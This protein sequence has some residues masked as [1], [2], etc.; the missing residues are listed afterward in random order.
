LVGGEGTG[1]VGADNGGA[2]ESFDGWEG[3]DDGVLFGHSV[4]TESQTGGD[5]GW[6]TFWDGGNSESDGNFEVVDGTFDP[7]ATVHWIVEVTDVDGPDKNAND[8]DH[9]G[10]L[11]TEFV[12]FFGEW[13]LF[14]FGFNHGLSDFTDF[15]VL[16][17]FS[18]DTDS[19]SRS[20]VGTR[21]EQID[22]ILIDGSVVWNSF[23]AFWYRNRFSGQKSLIDSESGG[24]DF[25]DSEI[26][27]DL[28]TNRNVNNIT[29]NKI[30]GENLLD[31]AWSVLSEDFGHG[32]LVFFQGFD[33]GF[34]VLFLPDTDASVGD[35]NGKND[36]WFDE[37][38]ENGVFNAL[39]FLLKKSENEGDTGGEKED[40][41]EKIFELFNNHSPEG[42]AFFW[43]HF[44][45][46]P[47]LSVGFD[48]ELAETEFWID[49]EVFA[50]ATGAFAPGVV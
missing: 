10:Q 1:F 21:K 23:G 22:F 33:G 42:F 37:G 9:F 8:G 19:F 24:F 18:N 20:D 15:G 41:D 31:L 29:W 35:Q 40:S 50:S 11:F 27:W 2:T 47:F 44:V 5:D 4:G 30:S 13:G 38:A 45:S 25:Q 32:W 49:I 17:G 26:G 14:S 43:W 28:V 46:A 36:Q 39:L 7:T 16:T 12:E 34:G 6:K 48:L 3:S